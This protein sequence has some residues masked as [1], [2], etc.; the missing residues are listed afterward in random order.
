MS[1]RYNKYKLRQPTMRWTAHCSI[2][3]VEC[4][5]PETVTACPPSQI[6]AMST[7]RPYCR[8]RP[9]LR[10]KQPRPPLRPLPLPPL[11]PATQQEYVH[12]HALDTS[13]LMRKRFKG[14]ISPAVHIRRS[15]VHHDRCPGRSRSACSNGSRMQH[16]P[17]PGNLK[18]AE[19]SRRAFGPFHWR[20]LCCRP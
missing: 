3:V 6:F 1:T 9:P 19:L 11:P 15:V 13:R 17:Q 20:P 10:L 18:S 7:T 2:R 16:H 8:H 5:S 4:F 12:T 14:I